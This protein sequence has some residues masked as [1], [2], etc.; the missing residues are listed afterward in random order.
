MNRLPM[1]VIAGIGTIALVLVSINTGGSD[2]YTGGDDFGTQQMKTSVDDR[3][4]F[5]RTRFIRGAPDEIT[6]EAC[7]MPDGRRGQEMFFRGRL[8]CAVKLD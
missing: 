7:T 2:F 6:G 3:R 1:I 5:A 8:G 4:T